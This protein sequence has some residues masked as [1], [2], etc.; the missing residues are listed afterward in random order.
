MMMMQQQTTDSTYPH[1][2]LVRARA[3]VYPRGEA[4]CLAP[5]GGWEHCQPASAAAPWPPVARPRVSHSRSAVASMLA[6]GALGAAA[7]VA[8]PTSAT[9]TVYP[10]SAYFFGNNGAQGADQAHNA[11]ERCAKSWLHSG[12]GLSRPHTRHA[13]RPPPSWR[14]RRVQQHRTSLRERVNGVPL[15]ADGAL[16]PALVAA[17]HLP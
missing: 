1:S 8:P 13:A 5:G 3:L 9:C 17:A 16:L 10:L 7:H 4:P 12:C 2:C 15:C 11:E 6:G 14:V